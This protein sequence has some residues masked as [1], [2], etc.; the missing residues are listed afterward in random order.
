MPR[1]A[2]PAWKTGVGG[3]VVVRPEHGSTTL[4]PRGKGE[5]RKDARRKGEEMGQDMA[6]KGQG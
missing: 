4:E 5:A 3:W 2:C 6:H 1:Q